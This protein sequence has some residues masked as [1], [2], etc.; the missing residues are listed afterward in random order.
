ML[1]HVTNA[2]LIIHYDYCVLFH[3]SC[4]TLVVVLGTRRCRIVFLV[5]LPP[6]SACTP[7]KSELVLEVGRR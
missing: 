1:E 7:L 4:V 2:I 5:I 6:L 3:L